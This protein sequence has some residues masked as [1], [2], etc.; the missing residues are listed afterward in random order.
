MRKFLHSKTKAVTGAA[1]AVAMMAA[2]GA[3]AATD[4][5]L[6][7]TSTGVSALTVNIPLRAL[8]TDVDDL[9]FTSSLASWD[10]SSN[11]TLTDSVCVFTSG[12]NY[13]VTAS[14]DENSGFFVGD[15]G[16]T[17]DFIE[18]SVQWAATAGGSSGTALTHNTIS[19]SNFA[20]TTTLSNCQGTPT[21]NATFIVTLDGST[22]SDSLSNAAAAT[23][24]TGNLTL[25]I[26]P[27]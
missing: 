5:T 21:N 17:E 2:T 27:E 23:N 25:V 13:Q 6:G 22:G 24:Y 15:Q 26:T 8:I 3:W 20:G 7:T 9:D 14:G 10:G 1:T 19:T 12:G 18:Y 4:G 11:V 16:G